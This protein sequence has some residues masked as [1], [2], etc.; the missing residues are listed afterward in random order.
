[1]SN[2]ICDIVVAKELETIIIIDD[3]DD[4]LRLVLEEEIVRII[5]PQQVVLV[6]LNRDYAENLIQFD[7]N[8]TTYV[9]ILS[10]DYNAK[11]DGE[12]MIDALV[13]WNSTDQNKEASFRLLIDSTLVGDELVLESN[14]NSSNA[15]ATASLF[16]K[17]PL[18]K[19]I[20]TF[21]LQTKAEALNQTVNVFRSVIRF[22]RWDE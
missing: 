16:K 22:Q 18:L 21:S 3:C 15:R 4:P 19:G 9:N 11:D 6:K 8:S 1:M 5:F 14:T 7:T 10:H 13:L 20:H 17:I 12:F 2:D